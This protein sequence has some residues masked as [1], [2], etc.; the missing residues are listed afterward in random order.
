[1][2]TLWST[3]AG[4]LAGRAHPQHHALRA[5]GA[6]A[7]A[8]QRAGSCAAP[9]AH[10]APGLPCEC[11]RH[12]LCLWRA[13][14]DPDR[15]QSQWT[16]HRVGHP[17]S[18]ADLPRL[19]GGP[20]PGLRRQCL[21]PVPDPGPRDRRHGW[22]MS[23]ERQETRRPLL[24]AF[25]GGILATILATPCS[26]PFVG[27]AVGFALRGDLSRSAP[28]SWPSALGLPCPISPSP[29]CRISSSGC[30]VPAAGCCG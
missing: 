26:A 30:R 4:G 10:G 11:R 14:A 25:L 1:M 29:A 17:V 13:G 28:S 21:G 8:D 19:P 15:R 16:E 2:P 27:T 6:A 20:V 12:R 22:R 24:G 9:R 3:L 23:T 18:A 5:A 7:E